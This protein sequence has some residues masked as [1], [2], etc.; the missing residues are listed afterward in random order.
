MA[1]PKNLSLVTA[2]NINI[3]EQHNKPVTHVEN[4]IKHFTGHANN[5]S[6]LLDQFIDLIPFL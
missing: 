6:C 4:C 3:P 1:S 2:Q 5:G